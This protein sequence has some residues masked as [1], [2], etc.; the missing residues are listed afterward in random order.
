MMSKMSKTTKKILSNVAQIVGL[1][2]AAFLVWF[3]AAALSDNPLVVPDPLEVVK[4]T[5]QLLG[6]G[7]TWL[8]LL[9]TL[10]R[11]AFA[12]AL[13]LTVAFLLA[14]TV[15]VFPKTRLVV[16]AVV[17]VLRAI[18]TIAVI[19]M[20]L[21]IFRSDSVP[22]VV[23]FLVAFPIIYSTFVRQ[24]EYNKQLF[25]VCKVFNVGAKNKV[26]YYILPLIKDELLPVTR[27]ELPLCIK[28]VIAGEVLALPVRAIGREM[29][30]GKVSIET[31]KVIALTLIVL[32]VCFAISGALSLI[33]RRHD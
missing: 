27:D 12:F 10:A 23:A 28:V 21:V 2:V 32:L 15:G 4:L 17:T 31:A 7:E 20:T 18:P 13:S 5:F 1:V 30:R 22:V 16:D 33:G 9:A 6:A 14:V 29:Y 19:L 8:S 24:F 11:S 25:D 26:G 3:A